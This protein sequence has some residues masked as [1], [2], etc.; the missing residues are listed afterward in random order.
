MPVDW[1]RWDANLTWSRNRVKDMV[2]TLTDGSNVNLGDQ[3]L[4]FSPDLIFN[5]IFTF[6][7]KGLKASVQSQYVGDQYLTNTGF[8]EMEC[9]DENGNT[10]YETLLLKKHFHTNVDLSYCFS[11]K[12]F[13]IQ[14][15]TAGVTFYNIFSAKYDNN[16]WAAPQLVNDNGSIKAVNEWGVRDSG[17][18]GFA[19]SAP[20]N[21]MGHLSVSF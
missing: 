8:K 4:A 18:A 6:K 2:V 12:K 1:F 16:G 19:P 15:I 7:Y 10:T 21:V 20:F 14:D 11:L 3:P 13:R 9:M 17:A 5:N